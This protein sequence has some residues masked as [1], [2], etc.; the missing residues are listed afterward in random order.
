MTK[1][2]SQDNQCPGPGFEPQTSATGNESTYNSTSRVRYFKVRF[3]VT[4]CD[5]PTSNTQFIQKVKKG[6]QVKYRVWGR[7]DLFRGTVFVFTW[8][9]AENHE[10]LVNM[11]NNV[12]FKLG[13]CS[14]QIQGFATTPTQNS[15]G[16]TGTPPPPQKKCIN[17]RPRVKRIKS[18]TYWSQNWNTRHSAAT[19]RAIQFRPGRFEPPATRSHVPFVR[20][21]LA[22]W[23]SKVMWRAAD[24]VTAQ[25]TSRATDPLVWG[26]S[27]HLSW[28]D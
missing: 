4:V 13:A 20:Q 6:K 8:R 9:S 1:D 3:I 24:T 15:Y 28:A 27:N 17:N 7:P 16:S 18:G 21:S 26:S 11:T 19:L 5:H 22:E 10:H 23:H 2:L 25:H 12:I 14:I